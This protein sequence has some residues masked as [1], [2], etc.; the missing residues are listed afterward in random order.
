V[1]RSLA[2]VLTVL[3]FA[4][5]ALAVYL[6]RCHR[7]ETLRGVGFGF[8]V[9]GVLALVVRALAG[10]AVTGS[11][12]GTAAVQPA[13]DAAWGIGTS[14]LVTIAV[15]MITFGILVVIGAWLAGP[16]RPALA[17]RREAAPYLRE[18]P[19][20]TYAAVA[21]V[22]L[23]LVLWAPVTAFQRPLGFLLLGVLLVLG[24]EVLRRQ[25]EAEFPDAT[26]GG[27]GE[28]IRGGLGRGRGGPPVTEESKVD[29]LER[30]SALRQQ[31]V[32]SEE[33]FAAAKAELLRP[34]APGG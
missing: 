33:E 32:L 21:L 26:F 28:R 25:A 18:R 30:L 31:G 12:A 5:Y 3:V 14:L 4:L 23:A 20:M 29:Q 24:T 34:A 15:S 6:A 7:R 2:I 1:I 22:F 16:T 13:V 9:A 11:L 8:I 10:H 27:F 19:G 17:L